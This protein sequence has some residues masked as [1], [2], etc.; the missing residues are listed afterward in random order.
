MESFYTDENEV[1]GSGDEYLYCQVCN[2]GLNGQTQWEA[3]VL[4]N[5]HKNN[6]KCNGKTKEAASTDGPLP[7]PDD[8]IRITLINLG[9]DKEGSIV[10]RKDD[11][12]Q[13]VAA[14]LHLA[15]PMLSPV[16]PVH[17]RN[18]TAAELEDDITVILRPQ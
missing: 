6:E 15:Y 1:P 7:V 11:T 8:H 18:I 12:W 16:P 4:G 9:G 17:A 3:H 5:L 13:K 14:A 2:M 10:V